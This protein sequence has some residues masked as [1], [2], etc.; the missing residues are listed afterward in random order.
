[1]AERANLLSALQQ[2]V[3]HEFW[4]LAIHLADSTAF[5]SARGSRIEWLKAILADLTAA[6]SVQ[7]VALSS[8]DE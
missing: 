5:L 2:A 7:I 4:N 8:S 6:C 1:M 3:L